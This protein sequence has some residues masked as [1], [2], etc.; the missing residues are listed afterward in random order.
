MARG[1]ALLWRCTKRRRLLCWLKRGLV[2]FL[3]LTLIPVLTWRW[4]P[5]PL[6]SVMLQRALQH[7]DWPE[8]EWVPAEAIAPVAALAVVAAED[9]TF[10]QHSGFDIDAILAA[11]RH[12]LEGGRLRGGSTISQ[13]LAK[14]LFLWEGRSWLRKGLE[15]WYTAWLELLWPKARI[16]EVYLNIAEMG[17][18][19]F[20]VE[21]A[22]RGFYAR[23]AK[24][25]NPAQAA[26]L[27][28]ALPNPRLYSADAP[29]AAMLK[30]RDW[31]LRQMKQLG[32]VDYLSP[33][34]PVR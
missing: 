30:R 16:L 20:G 9:Q 5:P 3:A 15:A 10:P 24:A 23:P 32:G 28:A 17:D 34:F 6:S 18:N 11:A 19:R 8:Y 29:S 14:N 2:T 26:T 21:A 4:L 33:V 25:L 1:R 7:G 27:A 22:A 12:N 31:I 13:Q